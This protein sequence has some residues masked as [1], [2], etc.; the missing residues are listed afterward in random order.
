MEE[1]DIFSSL[2]IQGILKNTEQC[3]RA[4]VKE[5]PTDDESDVLVRKLWLDD[6]RAHVYTL[7]Q[8]LELHSNDPRVVVGLANRI[9]LEITTILTSVPATTQ[10]SAGTVEV[11]TDAHEY[12]QKFLE[13]LRTKQER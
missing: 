9:S 12:I 5:Y 7:Y 1:M 2:N 13:Y 8:L 4:T 10:Y 11:L 6:L 3:F